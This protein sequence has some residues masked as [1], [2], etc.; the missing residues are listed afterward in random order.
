[1]AR[2]AHVTKRRKVQP[3][4]IYGNLLIAKFTNRLMLSG[5]KTVAQKVV[6]DA[7]EIIKEKGNMDPV[8]AFERAI[9]AVAPISASP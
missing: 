2:G 8:K 1:M 3:D 4:P 9:D 5:K 7:L 6:Y